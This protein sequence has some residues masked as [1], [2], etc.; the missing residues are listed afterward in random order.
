MAHSHSKREAIEVAARPLRELLVQEHDEIAAA[1]RALRHAERTHDLAIE[2]AQRQL[3]AAQ[4]A[5]P[6]ASYGHE[7]ILYADCLSTGEGNHAL[8]PEV[9]ARLE[10]EKGRSVLVIEAPGWRHEVTFPHRDNRKVHRLAEQ[11]EAA[12]INVEA[13]RRA[14]LANTREAERMLGGAHADRAAITEVRALMH[15]LGE[16]VKDDE[17]VIDMA[18]GISAGHDGVLVAT[19][20]RLLFVALRRTLVFPYEEISKVSV[21]GKWFGARLALSTAAGTGVISGISPRHAAEIGDLVRSR[22]SG[23]T[24]AA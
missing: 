2:L 8:T 13:I 12:A 9:K 17:D 3:R 4:T 16:L 19:D 23:E 21:K 6:L 10:T 7:V 11:I 5:E 18:P 14:D 15:R 20:H 1:Q 22:I 24:A